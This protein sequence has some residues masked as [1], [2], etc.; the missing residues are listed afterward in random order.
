[1]PELPEVYTIAKQLDQA[2]QGKV[3]AGVEV[4]REKSYASESNPNILLGKQVEGVERK[5]KVMGIRL[6]NDKVLA[7]HLKMTGQLIM[8]AQAGQSRIVGGSSS[9][10]LARLRVAG[11]SSSTALARLRVAG[12]HPTQD[13]VGQLPSKHTRMVIKFKDGTMLYFNDQRVFGWMKP[14][15]VQEWQSLKAKMPPDIIDAE[16]TADYLRSVMSRS[17]RPA[18]LVVMD[19]GLIGG[20]GNIY[21]NDA[22]FLAGISPI[23]PAN[24]V[25]VN[26]IKK[27]HTA[28]VK[29]IRRGIETGGASFSHYLNTEGLGGRYQDEFVVYSREGELC[30]NQCGGEIAKMRLGGRGTYFCAKCQ[31]Q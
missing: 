10:A 2:L 6:E 19:S 30:P 28:L 14:M 9:T 12:G 18:K 15:S 26:A 17:R 4:L 13:W 1:M 22:L 24:Q 31:R 25:K 7:V 11:G 20:A 5:G 8:V 23:R 3:I 16:F 21:A 29:V 27:L